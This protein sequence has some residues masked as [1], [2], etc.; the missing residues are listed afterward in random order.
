[1]GEGEVRPSVEKGRPK[2]EYIELRA[3]AATPGSL[4]RECRGCGLGRFVL[5]VADSIRQYVRQNRSCADTPKIVFYTHE[6]QVTAMSDAPSYDAAGRP[7][8]VIKTYTVALPDVGLPGVGYSLLGV[9]PPSAQD[10]SV[11]SLARDFAEWHAMNDGSQLEGE[12]N[13]A[14]IP[15]VLSMLVNLVDQLQDGWKMKVVLRSK[16]IDPK[17]VEMTTRLVQYLFGSHDAIFL[18]EV[19][20][21]TGNRSLSR[22]I[23]AHLLEEKPYIFVM[24]T[25]QEGD[26]TI[27]DPSSKLGR[28][29]R[30][31]LVGGE[32]DMVKLLNLFQ[33]QTSDQK[34]MPLI[35]RLCLAFPDDTELQGLLKTYNNKKVELE[36][37]KGGEVLL[38][39]HSENIVRWLSLDR[40]QLSLINRFY[41]TKSPIP[42][43]P[44]F[45]DFI[46]SQQ[47]TLS[48]LDAFVN[49]FSRS[50]DDYERSIRDSQLIPAQTEAIKALESQDQ[51]LRQV[52]AM[53]LK[54]SR[55]IA[56]LA[57][58]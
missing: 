26:S 42:R 9:L 19:D 29:F 25:E 50:L 1:M 37:A 3:R 30:Q 35:E 55:E 20:D 47:I 54:L 24:D 52:N 14:N 13:E 53:I 7:D 23:S 31:K 32:L 39:R 46:S 36:E 8:Q 16:G 51:E 56:S 40:A 5:G 33:Q 45:A 12:D 34:K 57:I 49:G 4:I 21:D 48:S 2:V 27:A 11:S 17:D 22:A 18:R 28:W 10:G 58:Y 6:G 38:K 43:R 15:R 41:K 44:S